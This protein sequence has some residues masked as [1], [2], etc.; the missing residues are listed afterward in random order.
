MSVCTVE[1]FKKQTGKLATYHF[2]N[3]DTDLTDFSAFYPYHPSNPCPPWP[4]FGLS[5]KLICG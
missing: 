5:S 3:E 1:F 2:Q 4:I